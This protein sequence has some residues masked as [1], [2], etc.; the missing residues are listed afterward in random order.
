[1]E[2][3]TK[4]LISSVN[5]IRM[6]KEKNHIPEDLDEFTYMPVDPNQKIVLIRVDKRYII[7][8]EKDQ[9]SL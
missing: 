1:M 4:W 8:E 6:L 9:G 2:K 5:L 3:R 7:Y